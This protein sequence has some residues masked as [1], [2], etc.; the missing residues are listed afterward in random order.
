LA[1]KVSKTKIGVG[2]AKKKFKNKS[3]ASRALDATRRS[4]K[5]L[6]KPTKEWAKNPS[7]ADVRGIDD[8]S[9]AAKDLNK[10]VISDYFRKLGKK[11]ARAKKAKAKKGK[12]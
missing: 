11:G 10:Q 5:V 2:E 6:N 9:K 8:G 3:K 7:V 12:N 4:R 1:S